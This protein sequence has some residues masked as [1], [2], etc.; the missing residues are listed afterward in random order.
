MDEAALSLHHLQESNIYNFV[1]KDKILEKFKKK[2]KKYLFYKILIKN[3]RTIVL[4]IVQIFAKKLN[5]SHSV[6]N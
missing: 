4:F 6:Y 1:F 2:N 3:V 5:N